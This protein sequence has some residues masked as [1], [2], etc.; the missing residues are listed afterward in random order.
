MAW[1]RQTFPAASPPLEQPRRS[2]EQ[3]DPEVP[4]LQGPA[5]AC[6]LMVQPASVEDPQKK[7]LAPHLRPVPGPPPAHSKVPQCCGF[8][9]KGEPAGPSAQGRLETS[10]PR[11]DSRNQRSRWI[12]EGRTSVQSAAGWRA[13][14][15]APLQAHPLS[16]KPLAIRK[17]DSSPEDLKPA[18]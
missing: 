2:A 14:A 11:E 10:A 5:V 15:G 4:L 8:T 3:Q 6:S 1:Q 18:T 13:A 17:G 9:P 16:R 7:G 12:L